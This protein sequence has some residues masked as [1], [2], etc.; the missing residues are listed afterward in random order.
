VCHGGVKLPRLGIHEPNTA[1]VRADEIPG[2]VGIE[3]EQFVGI[4]LLRDSGGGLEYDS[5]NAFRF[6]FNSHVF[7]R[8]GAANLTMLSGFEPER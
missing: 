8:G 1:S 7:T 3:L 2:H 6:V 5:R 4:L